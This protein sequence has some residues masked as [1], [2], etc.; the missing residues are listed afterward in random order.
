MAD[1]GCPVLLQ[2]ISAWI[3]TL[4]GLSSNTGLP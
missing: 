4:Q 2:N 3:K 1:A